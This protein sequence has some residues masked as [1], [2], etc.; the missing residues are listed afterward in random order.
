MKK[1]VVLLVSLS[2]FI[3][4]KKENKSK[5]S[6]SSIKTEQNTGVTRLKGEFVYHGDAAVLQT[7]ND[8]YGVFIT[9][10]ML[11]LENLAK[12]YKK[13][14]T[15]MVEVEITGKVT[16]QKDDK[17]LWENKV[18]IVDILNVSPSNPE[19]NNVVKIGKE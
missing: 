19:Q 1:I 12:K 7:K 2:I 17:I 9:D 5:D 16:N 15:D 14:S 8:I 11:E 13:E 10:K 3:S 6:E 18:E 4:C